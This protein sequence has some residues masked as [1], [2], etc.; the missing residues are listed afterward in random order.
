[1]RNSP[2]AIRLCLFGL[3]ILLLGWLYFRSAAL[4]QPFRTYTVDGVTSA[5]EYG[6][7]ENLGVSGNGTG[8][9]TNATWDSAGNLYFSIDNTALVNT[10]ANLYVVV[11]TDPVLA[12]PLAGT[13][14]AF[15]PTNA[16]GGMT[17][18]F[19]ANTVFVIT[20]TPTEDTA[21]QTAGFGKVY[22]ANGTTWANTN[23]TTSLGVQLVRHSYNN[24]Q[25]V[26][27]LKIP[28]T[29]LGTLGD[30]SSKA[31]NL[32]LYLADQDLTGYVVSIWPATNPTTNGTRATNYF[33]WPL[34]FSPDVT[35]YPVNGLDPVAYPPAI[36]YVK[37]DYSA[38]G[39]NDNH[40]WGFDAFNT[41][42][43]ALGGAVPG[44]AVSVNDGTYNEDMVLNQSG[45][46]VNLAGTDVS[47]TGNFKLGAGSFN[48][49]SASFTLGGDLV[50]SGGN[51]NAGNSTLQFSGNA[52][53][54]LSLA[55]PLTLNALTIGAGALVTETASADNL[56][57]NGSLNNAGTIRKIQSLVT[58]QTTSFGLT[59]VSIT[60]ANLNGNNISV[61]ID[62]LDSNLVGAPASLQ[63]GR[64]WNSSTT[65][66]NASANVT[67][68]L[69]AGVAGDT[70][71][72]CVR[73]GSNWQC[74]HSTNTATTV[75][76][77]NVTLTGNQV[78]AIGDNTQSA[79]SFQLTS[80]ATAFQT[81]QS[82]PF[83]LTAFDLYGNVS[84]SYTGTVSFTSD[85]PTAVFSPLFYT[86][87]PSDR[88]SVPFRTVFNTAGIHIITATDTSH[89]LLTGAMSGINVTAGPASL[90]FSS[91][92]VS[93]NLNLPANFTVTV[94]TANGTIMPDFN[95][96][97]VLSSTDSSVV[98]SPT[99]YTYNGSDNGQ[100]PFA[101]TFNTPGSKIITA[102]IVNTQPA[103]QQTVNWAVLNSDPAT[104]FVLQGYPSS[105]AL[106]DSHS[107][108]VTALSDNGFVATTYT[109]TVGFT[110][111]DPAATFQ[112]PSYTFQPG[113]GGQH[114]F[115]VTFH[116][117]G[118]QAFTAT[119]NLSQA[120]TGSRVGIAVSA[121]PSTVTLTLNPPEPVYGQSIVIQAAVSP[122]DIAA[123]ST[124][125]LQNL[126][127]PVAGGFLT[128]SN[129]VNGV[130]TA[131][132]LPPYNGLVIGANPLQAVFN[133]DTTTA[134]A[135]SQPVTLTLD[136]APTI[137]SL[138][139]SP[140]VSATV[141]QIVTMTALVSSSVSIPTGTI[142]FYN[143][144]SWLS[145]RP[146]DNN[147]QAVYTTTLPSGDWTFMAVYSGTENY[148]TSTSNVLTY[149]TGY[150]LGLSLSSSLVY[151]GVPVTFTTSIEPV[152]A[153]QPVTFTLTPTI[154]SPSFGISTFNAVGVA[155]FSPSNLW[156]GVYIVQSHYANSASNSLTLTVLPISTTL[157]LT[158]SSN[159]VQSG[160]P[161]T[162]TA[163]LSPLL[164]AQPVQFISDSTPLGIISTSSGGTA[165]FTT[166][167]PVGTH[168][169]EAAY[170][171]SNGYA[172]STSPALV[173]IV[174]PPPLPCDPLVV[175]ASQDSGDA[176][177]C[178]TLSDALLTASSG[179]TITFNLSGTNTIS[180]TGILTPTIKP[181]VT[182]YGGVCGNSGII[183]NGV[184]GRGFQLGGRN[185]LVNLWIRGFVGPQLTA[186]R[187]AG[188]NILRCVRV[189]PH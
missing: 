91:L 82:N 87:T 50:A 118:T 64:Y 108:T 27:E 42:G 111:T 133:G 95:G 168:T 186:P 137:T 159:T 84:T 110:S 11:D 107:F 109:G 89:S 131:T 52:G 90:D 79:T 70:A 128:L 98:F 185:R 77:A 72:V 53:H 1:M 86:F 169:I 54:N 160:Q 125:A 134:P 171:G 92:A 103:I 71:Q 46:S 7:G 115:T 117:S 88:G 146:L 157:S 158:S 3:L 129:P 20:D 114:I 93:G 38:A 170:A 124:I 177:T 106:S 97:V 153:N 135:S 120:L 173:V 14:L 78:W 143:G 112:P 47:L 45:V 180:L 15:Q 172:A 116:T 6:S 43:T 96:T 56:T 105:V 163:Q 51:F 63:T 174:L 151:Y 119:D 12:N 60:T 102:T 62:R 73:T 44:T 113:D 139:L 178:G 17:Y 123:T 30:T 66:G 2:T 149:K 55:I 67:L 31:T 142:A 25:G 161:L 188:G 8:H 145:T 58:G 154:G 184:S 36:R 59:G 147:G 21:V 132:L 130:V 127:L 37:P 29:A 104:S 10:N 179:V 40:L 23:I 5:G 35:R 176:S 182:I 22:R 100:H 28:A 69:P 167:L 16:S 189:S 152:V 26:T 175:T 138:S 164:A 136:R 144:S 155:V 162:L 49:G 121:R 140:P 4:A 74:G 18:P 68:P 57:V 187:G 181:G 166:T 165:V 9:T 101:V 19:S 126:A 80:P 83:N 156:P 39:T 13:G 141:G 41:L 61:Q 48:L 85:D 65:G 122:P 183:I 94:R 76:L 99:Q 150:N 32:L 34:G 24:H 75:T 33:Y 148:L 81:G